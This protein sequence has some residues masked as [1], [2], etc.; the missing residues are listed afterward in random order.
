MLF[1]FFFCCVT[2]T[3]RIGTVA[4]NL[5]SVT[6]ARERVGEVSKIAFGISNSNRN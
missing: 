6:Q 3:P 1:V 5:V 4:Q 2:A